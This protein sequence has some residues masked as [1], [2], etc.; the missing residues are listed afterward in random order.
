[1]SLKH[2]VVG[3]VAWNAVGLIIDNG[4]Q[5]LV[6]LILA[7]L[8]VPEVFGIVGFATVFIGMIQVFSDLGMTA[9]LIQRKDTHLKP[10]DYDTAFWAGIAWSI[11]LIAILSFIIGPF[12]AYFYNE[13]LLITIMP[14]LSLSLLFRNLTAVHIVNITRE[15]E[16][17]KIVLP[18][19]ISRILSSVGAII[20]AYLGFGVWSIV[21]QSVVS[22]LLLSI[23]Y[24]YVSPWKP[25][26]RFSKRSFRNIFGFGVYTTGT[27]I[28]NYLTGNI[29]YLMI[30]KLLGAHPLGVYTLG[31]NLTYVVRGQI[32]NVINSVFYP[33]YSKIQ[34]DLEQTKKYYFKVIKYNCIVIYPLM[35]G[36]ILLAKPLVIYGL[37]EKW[38]ESIIPMQYMA[39]AG[40][41]HLLTSSNTV[42]LR[43]LGKPNL[44]L[45][46]SIIKTLG[47]NVP[48]IVIG[49]LLNGII[50]AAQGLF[51]AKIVIFF[52]N[53][54]TLNKVAKIKFSE[55]LE[56]AGTLFL[57]TTVT[58][59]AVFITGN[60]FILGFIFLVYLIIH[61]KIS[62][63]DIAQL[64]KVY[65]TRKMKQ[66]VV[67]E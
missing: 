28:F 17:K 50:G 30:G 35:I 26:L 57:I 2:K 22:D 56:N 46:F 34:D 39:A 10:I 66:V 1:V 37:G 24:S 52:I 8:L 31:Y 55:I 40:L 32:M 54:Y 5:I 42:L 67:T 62:W 25:K 61:I 16:F 60:Y 64:L 14:V 59:L 21:F 12:A 9:A 43:G 51:L 44:E 11:F 27:N 4:L 29:D 47:V 15:M 53:N 13:N 49:V 63:Q 48:F 3:G 7:R 19:N 23:L 45:L 38:A 18:R 33:V 20:L 58:A 41:V 65:K 36:L 6:K